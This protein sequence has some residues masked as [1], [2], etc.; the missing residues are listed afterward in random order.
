MCSHFDRMIYVALYFLLARFKFLAMTSVTKGG[1]DHSVT[2]FS[3]IVIVLSL[4]DKTV[5]VE[6][7]ANL[8]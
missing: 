5:F 2:S 3:S 1:R 8:L 6:S 4:E 7:A